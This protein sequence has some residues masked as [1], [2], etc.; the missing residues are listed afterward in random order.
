MKGAIKFKC[1]IC[2]MGFA[3]IKEKLNHQW[4]E[5]KERQ[6][7]ADCAYCGA[8]FRKKSDIKKHI[9]IHHNAN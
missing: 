1:P 9:S 8:Q 4:I 2:K 3:T 6:T 5:H 7:E